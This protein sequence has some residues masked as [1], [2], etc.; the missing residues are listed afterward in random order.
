MPRLH[1]QRGQATIDYVALIAFLAVLLAA[2][3]ALAASGAA[4]FT[5]AVVGQIRHALCIVT[6]SACLAERRLPCVVASDRDTRH[7]AVTLAIVRLDG[8]RYVLREHMS[9]GTVR[10]T[11]AH[12]GG[13]GAEF[14]VGGH[15]NLKLRGRK[16]AVD[17][18]L[19]GGG[20]GIAG[21][22]EV[23][24]A[25]DDHEADEILRKLRHRVPLVSHDGL[26]PSE[27]FVEGGLR[28]LGRLG[29][30]G[31]AAG[32][33]LAGLSE[34]VVKATRDERSG[35][36]TIALSSSA[37]A[38]GLLEAVMSGPS[39]SVDRSAALSVTLDRGHR[40]VE[41]SLSASGTL[42]AGVAL[43]SQ[44]AGAL[45]I[46]GGS[47]TNLA[48][49]RWD[50]GVRVDLRDPDVVAAWDAFR[51][52]PTSSDAIGALGATMRDRAQ[53][54]GHTY[55]VRSES[56]GGGAGVALGI[57]IGGE[58]VRTTDRARLLSAATRP[59]GGL[60][61]QRRDCVAA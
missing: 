24:V 41:L 30:G 56:D 34:N 39:G 58:Y 18:E 27:V 17:D 14:G 26:D 29:L 25:R 7:A 40:P 28:G 47:Q 33:S 49:R 13:L 42:Q 57:K 23:Y 22:G 1:Q 3:A 12:T 36:I 31:S 16:V 32:A 51:H 15:V 54:D 9:D 48:G 50:V 20:E 38:W 59:P 53:I 21:Y 60:W 35:Q 10:L 5:N 8:D 4:G 55:A 52:D 45:G 46:D 2:A 37:S 44:V 11:L 43:P 6:G 19:S 61:E